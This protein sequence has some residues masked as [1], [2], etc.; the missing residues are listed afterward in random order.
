MFSG[1]LTYEGEAGA[2][3]G[4]ERRLGDALHG[5][6]MMT[7]GAWIFMAAWILGM[8]VSVAF[9]SEL[10]GF[11]SFSRLGH[12]DKAVRARFLGTDFWREG[13]SKQRCLRILTPS[14]RVAHFLINVT[15]RDLPDSLNGQYLWLCW[16]ADRGTGGKR[17]S[18]KGTPAALV[19]D[20]GWVMHGMLKSR[21][22]RLLADEGIPVEKAHVQTAGVETTEVE[23]AVV[24]AAVVQTAGPETA[25]AEGQAPRTLRL[26]D[27]R[28]AWPLFM[29][30]SA[31]ALAAL[32]V[33]CGALLTCDI[34]GFWRWATA[35]TGVLAGCALVILSTIHESLLPPE[36]KAR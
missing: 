2:I 1:G 18:P 27:P 34:P 21:D 26:W 8:G 7:W 9:V 4:D 25:A 30:P 22:A 5:D 10:Y 11:R 3:A 13:T 28:S 31:P 32:T 14:S 20:D 6:T 16:D 17:F 33:A 24:E 15:D 23:A 19:S 12:A 35:I 36:E 29:R